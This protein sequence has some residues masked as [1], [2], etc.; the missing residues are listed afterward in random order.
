MAES[1]SG[2]GTGGTAA[3]GAATTALQT[4]GEPAGGAGPPPPAKSK[5][6]RAPPL[7]ATLRAA[8]PLAFVGLWLRDR[9]AARKDCAKLAQAAS[10]GDDDASPLEVTEAQ[11]KEWVSRVVGSVKQSMVAKRGQTLNAA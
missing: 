4:V 2:A 11:A 6:P 9:D 5:K 10:R 1:P 3:A 7:T 8:M